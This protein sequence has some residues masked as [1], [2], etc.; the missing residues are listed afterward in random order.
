M[1][2]PRIDAD[3]KEIDKFIFNTL[4]SILHEKVPEYKSMLDLGGGSGYASDCSTY[5]LMNEFAVF[6]GD[7]IKE[8][9]TGAFVKKS[10]EYI[11]LLG[12]SD[13]RE[14][15]N[16]VHVGIL[17][18]LYSESGVDRAWVTMNLS[19]KL[20]TYFESWSEYYR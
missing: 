16:I 20:R 6:L 7:R 13:N 14:I 8:D 4:S 9:A 15:L 12:Q 2:N 11:N 17:E 19:D 1:E 3:L 5:L 18:I 10:F